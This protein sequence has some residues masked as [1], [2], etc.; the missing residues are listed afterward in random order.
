MEQAKANSILVYSTSKVDAFVHQQ[1]AQIDVLK[2]NIKTLSDAN[3]A[4]TKRIN[5]LEKKINKPNP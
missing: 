4:L 1:Q 3:D 2:D 5:E